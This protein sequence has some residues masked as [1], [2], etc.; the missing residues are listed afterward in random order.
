M[1]SSFLSPR[2]ASGNRAPL[3]ASLKTRPHRE[4][5]AK[6]II[7]LRA[8]T[9]IF[10]S[11]DKLFHFSL[12][13]ASALTCLNQQLKRKNE[14]WVHVSLGPPHKHLWSE[15]KKKPSTH[16]FTLLFILPARENHWQV[17]FIGEGRQCWNPYAEFSSRYLGSQRYRT[18]PQGP[19]EKFRGQQLNMGRTASWGN[20]LSND[21]E[22]AT[23][24]GM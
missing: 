12:L 4:G 17:S 15:P 20:S 23:V 21:L 24:C 16:F 22:L 2:G 9:L 19:E 14:W 1:K 7:G 8:R 5:R 11:T 13:S 18:G 10:P 3:A 6:S